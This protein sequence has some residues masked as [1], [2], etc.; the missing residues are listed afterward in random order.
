MNLQSPTATKLL[1]GL[2]LAILLAAG[3]LFVLSPQTSAMGDVQAQIQSTRDQNDTL[4]LQLIS[5]QRQEKA[6]GAT[7]ADATALAK[8]FP[9]TADQPGLFKD[10]T[11]AATRAGIPARNVTA[12]TPTPPVVGSASDSAGVQLP[13]ESTNPDLARQTVTLSVTGSYHQTQQ[14]VANLEQMPRAYLIN[15]LTLAGGDTGAFTTTITGDMFVMPP[16]K[17]PKAVPES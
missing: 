14:L 12:L 10:V 13:G 9:S 2:A 5:L 8:M 4:R 3:W 16:A 6:L 17:Q 7:R 1:G 15:S 11:A